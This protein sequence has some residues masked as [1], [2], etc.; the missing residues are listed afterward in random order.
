[1]INKVDRAIYELKQSGEEIYQQFQKVIE[2]V[3]TVICNY[4]CEEMG[5][6]ECNPTLG[7]VVFGAG[8]DQWAFSLTTFARIY[9]K[10]FGVPK[11]TLI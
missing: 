3:N 8:K 5:S 6:L 2:M 10:K 11:E 7:N 4:Q 9:E 1:M